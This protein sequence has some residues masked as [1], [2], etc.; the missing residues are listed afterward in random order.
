MSH[1]TAP[2]ATTARIQSSP[3]QTFSW[4][5]DGSSPAKSLRLRPPNFRAPSLQAGSFQS[6]S[7]Q[8]AK[9]Q[10]AK[11]RA[12]RLIARL[13]LL[14]GL[15]WF[16]PL[17][18]TELTLAAESNSAG[19]PSQ[20]TAKRPNILWI[21]SEDNGPQMG[22]YGDPLAR[23]PNLDALAAR[24]MI[25]RHAWSNAPVCA[26]ARTTLISGIFPTSSG[27]EHMR[28]ETR[29]PADVWMYPQYLREAG[30]YC[31]NNSKEDYNLAK[32]AGLWDESSRQ[33]HWKNRAPGQPFFAIFNSVVSHESQIRRRPH[34]LITDPAEVRIPAYHPDTPEVRRDWAQYY[35]VVAEMDAIAGEQ[36]RE[37]EE[38]GLQEETIVFYYGDHGPGM[39]RG[40][41][42]PYNSGLAVPLIVYIPEAFAHL[43]PSAYQPGGESQR[44]VSFVDLPPT[45]LSLIGVEPPDHFQGRA[46]LGPHATPDP[47]YIH[48]FRGRMDERYDL[49][50]SI[51]DQRYVYVRNYMPHLIYGQYLAYM[52]ETPTTQVWR[53][54]Y[55]EGKLSPP[56]TYFWEP[57][58]SEEL[59]DLEQDPDEVVNLA[60]SPEHQE[61]KARLQTA[62][63]SWILETRDLGFLP[64]AEF[65]ARAGE[66]TPY[67]LA[68]DNARYPL[69][70]IL[71]MAE[72]ASDRSQTEIQPLLEGLESEEAGIRY[73]SLIGLAVRGPKATRTALAQLPPLLRDSS[74]SCQILAAQYLAEEGTD[75]QRAEAMELL[76][77]RAHLEDNS[78]YVSMQALNSLDAVRLGSPELVAPFRDTLAQLPRQ[79]EGTPPRLRGYVPRLLEQILGENGG[80]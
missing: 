40:K 67:E 77:K 70:A 16:A 4:R 48:G 57:K 74:P 72:W 28:S 56:K 24:G 36:L 52:F 45:L 20:G 66:E 73:W 15:T 54:L 3:F 30:Y 69:A 13:M 38:A 14:M 65:H 79:V 71:A 26:P 59:Y 43:R 8:S 53:R 61:I 31:T 10:P 18:S 44:L 58:P 34:T 21:T 51:R 12:T 6:G 7:F 17:P 47:E 11:F 29:L 64:E 22:C 80:P 78:L 35:D 62:L 32:P 27:S 23:T 55:D 19:V 2:H 63:R 1:S 41:R 9:L 5:L 50:R 60:D 75:K 37:L 39:P 33:A 25:Y 49:V 42:W 46:F 68:R 76:L